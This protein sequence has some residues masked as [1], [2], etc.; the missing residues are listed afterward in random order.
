MIRP[1]PT[2]SIAGIRFRAVLA[3][4]AALG[5]LLGATAFPFPVTASARDAGQPFPCSG[6][7]CGCATAEECW[8]GDC[9]CFT[10]EQKVVWAE[11]NGIEPPAHVPQVLAQRKAR[12]AK[13]PTCCC[14]DGS[15][16]CHEAN[17]SKGP[18]CPHCVAEQTHS[19]LKSSGQT[20]VRWISG[21]MAQ[22]CHG[23]DWSA[24]A[25][26]DPSTRPDIENGFQLK[27]PF[28]GTI[29]LLPPHSQ[30]LS[31]EPPSPPPRVS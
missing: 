1:Q 20:T 3:A 5:Q 24:V 11:A 19:D 2:R 12:A 6:H 28:S 16:H 4:L 21:F 9:C 17:A 13:Q 27:S 8:Q 22:R 7:A 14:A 26:S 10:L 29:M 25:N 15:G 18:G 31:H 30:S 23:K